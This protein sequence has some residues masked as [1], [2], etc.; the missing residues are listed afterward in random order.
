M[1]WVFKKCLNIIL[2]YENII[3]NKKPWY[4]AIIFF[5]Q[6]YYVSQISNMYFV[7]TDQFP[8]RPPSIDYNIMVSF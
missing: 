7:T 8:E 4:C 1:A 2:K 6:K 3:E 5:L